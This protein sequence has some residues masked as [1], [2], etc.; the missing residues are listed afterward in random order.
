VFLASLKLLEPET[1]APTST[2]PS[3]QPD[4]PASE[5]PWVSNLI[6]ECFEVF[7]DPLPDG[8]PPM[9]KK[10]HNI[11]TELGHPPSF[12]QKY[13]LSPLEYSELEKQVT[14]FLKAGIL[15]VSTSTYGAPVLFVPKPNGRGLR[16]CID[17]RA[18]NAITIKNRCTILR[19]DDLLDA[20]Q[21]RSILLHWIRH[22]VIIRY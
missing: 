12:W 5:K 16:L 7:Q 18:L 21:D 17:Y 15:E 19:I 6:G 9:R 4:H 20:I 10:V 8:L 13:R 2:S 11:P 1:A 22:L 14:A 3:V